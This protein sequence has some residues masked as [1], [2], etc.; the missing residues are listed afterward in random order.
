MSAVDWR[1]ATRWVSTL[2]L[3]LCA[4]LA[5]WGWKLGILTSEQAMAEFVTAAGAAGILL[6]TL[7]QA[8]QVVLPILPGGIGCLVGV[9]LFGP[10]KGFFCNYIGICIGSMLAFAISKSYGRPLLYKLF[11]P[12]LIEKYESWTSP[13]SPFAKWFA[14]AIFLPVAP[15]DFLCY[16]AGTTAMRFRDF[17]VIIWL[18]KP[19][20]IAAYSLGLFLLWEQILPLFS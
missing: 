4:G 20:A 6:F 8:V 14:L 3:L 5:A 12:K 10:V 13:E 2:G 7:F 17:F 18:C 16:L 15:D 1:T 19:A 9:L 11:S